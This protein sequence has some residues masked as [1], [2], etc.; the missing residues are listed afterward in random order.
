MG[1]AFGYPIEFM[2]LGKIK[3]DPND[4]MKRMMEEAV[5]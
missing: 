1:D 4:M 3:A 2:S 5:S